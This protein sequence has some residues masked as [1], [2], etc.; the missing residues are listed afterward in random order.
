MSNRSSIRWKP[1]LKDNH[2]P[3]SKPCSA[4]QQGPPGVASVM[5]DKERMP[6]PGP[7]GVASAMQSKQRMLVSDQLTQGEQEVQAENKDDLAFFNQLSGGSWPYGR[8][9][10]PRPASGCPVGWVGGYRYSDN[11]DFANINSESIGVVTR[12]N[13]EVGTNTN[14]TYCVKNSA[15]MTSAGSWPSGTYCIARKGGSCPTGFTGGSV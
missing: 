8:Y 11:E 1:L 7:P 14:K 3:R 9:A 6:E 2:N 10:L 4:R 13:V 15:G 12:M 5:Q